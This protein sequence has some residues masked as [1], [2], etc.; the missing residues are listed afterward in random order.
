MKREDVLKEMKESVGQK[1][2]VVFFEKMVD[3]LNLL[4]DR[5]E[6]MESDLHRVKTYSAL[7]ISWEPRVASEMLSRQIDILRQ[8]KDTYHTEISALKEAFTKNLVTQNYHDF[9]SFWLDTL[10]WHPFLD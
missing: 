7:A 2:P 8:D 3:V 5:M 4:F 1:E 10:G 9:T 6:K